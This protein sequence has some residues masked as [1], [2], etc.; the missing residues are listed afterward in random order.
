MESYLAKEEYVSGAYGLEGRYP[1][2]DRA[3]V[4]EFLW[5]SADLKN[6]VYKN[7]LDN[8]LTMHNYPFQRGVKTGF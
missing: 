4:Q 1:F 7:V 3:V 6:S 8:Y 5:L 2:L